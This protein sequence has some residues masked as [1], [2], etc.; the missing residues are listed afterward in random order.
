MEAGRSSK[1][2]I[3]DTDEGKATLVVE[4]VFEYLVSEMTVFLITWQIAVLY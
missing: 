3:A 2:E 4:I 1:W